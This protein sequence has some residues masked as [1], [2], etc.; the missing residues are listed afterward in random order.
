MPMRNSTFLLFPLLVCSLASCKESAPAPQHDHAQHHHEDHAHHQPAADDALGPKI[1]TG[2]FLLSVAPAE[3]TYTIGQAGK[4]EIALESRGPW[5]VNQEYPIR[6]DLN[7]EP[8]VTLP[9]T[10]LAK[11]DAEELGETKVR[12]L[13]AVEP[14]SAGIH[15][16][17]CDVSFALCTDDNCVLEKRTVALALEV[18]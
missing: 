4:V 17:S 18:Q 8:G 6:V 12:F 9:R 11:G 13:A 16:V 2:S 5:H 3:Q 10:E 7:A 1:E 14:A 15:D